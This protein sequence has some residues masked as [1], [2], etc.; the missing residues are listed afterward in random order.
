MSDEEV[1]Q[2][3]L[4]AIESDRPDPDFPSSA[5]DELKDPVHGTQ[6][7]AGCPRPIGRSTFELRQRFR[8]TGRPIERITPPPSPR[9]KFQWSTAAPLS[10]PNISKLGQAGNPRRYCRMTESS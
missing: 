1:V 7:C 5:M 6:G 8:S 10:L 9:A 2:I 3:F 4:T